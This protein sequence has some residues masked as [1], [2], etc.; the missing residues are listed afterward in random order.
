MR[1]FPLI[2]R[3][4]LI[5]VLTFFL[6]CMMFAIP[7][8]SL[9]EISKQTKIVEDIGYIKGNIRLTS[10]RKGP[11]I[12]LH[13]ED[14]KGVPALRSRV[15]ATSNGDFHFVALPGEHYIAAFIDSNK[16][17]HYQQGEHGNFYG[18]PTIINVAPHQTVILKTI[19]IAGPLPKSSTKHK[20]VDKTRAVWTNI[21]QVTTLNDPRFARKNYDM[22]LWKPFDFL[23]VAEGGL[24]FLQKYQRRKVPVIF[25]HGAKGGPADWKPVIKR[26][27][28]RRFQAWVLYYPSGMRLDTISD[29]LVEAISRLQV[30]YGFERYYVVAH[31][32]G[33]L[34]TRSFVKKN[35]ERANG[36]L[37][38]P[39]LVVTINSPMN[40][41]DSASSGVK[42]SP[43]VVPSWR[44]IESGSS[45]L[46]EIHEWN[47]P[48]EVPYH[49]VVSYKDGKSGDGV[50]SLQSSV[51]L[52]LQSE[53]TR[54]YVF[55]NTHVG[56]L[57]DKKFLVLLNRILKD[58]VGK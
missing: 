18:S 21:G 28:K 58:N 33:G 40:G 51:P 16:D 49:L 13:L 2:F 41:M 46:K 47:W 8:C 1:Y 56:T 50:A 31:S 20:A 11:V 39:R 27:D 53:S 15:F 48:Q 35:V 37:T 9:N 36:S 10:N 32:M 29:Y 23:D 55:N 24:F 45:F 7:G 34:V 25:V 43:I 14:H 17:G 42:Y 6:W 57:S 4:Q 19:T 44:D 30:K 54:L 3:K 26:L 22:G 38:T 12:V 5:P 52:K